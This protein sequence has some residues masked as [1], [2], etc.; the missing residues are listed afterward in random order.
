MQAGQKSK[1][2]K[3]RATTRLKSYPQKKTSTMVRPG[4]IAAAH[5]YRRKRRVMNEAA[6]GRQ[7][8][9]DLSGEEM[10]RL[11]YNQNREPTFPTKRRKLTLNSCKLAGHAR[12]HSDEAAHGKARADQGQPSIEIV[13]ASIR[14]IQVCDQI[15]SVMRDL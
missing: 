3:E 6:R 15:E 9:M 7:R 2:K 13:H 10:R 12:Q 4:A 14:P 11:C 5:W 8:V 1:Q